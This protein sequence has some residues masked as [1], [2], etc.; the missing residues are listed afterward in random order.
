MRVLALGSYHR[1]A[2]RNRILLRGLREC[3][4]L[5]SERRFPM[6]TLKFRGTGLTLLGQLCRVALSLP[7]YCGHMVSGAGAA[8]EADVVFIGYLGHHDVAAVAA[9]RRVL[10]GLR[11]KPVVF[12]PF[13]S[14]YDTVVSDRGLLSPRCLPARVLWRSE[15]WLLTAADLVLADTATHGAYYRAMAGLPPE[16]VRVVPVGVDEALFSARE[17]RPEAGPLRIL[18][19]GTYIPLHGIETILRAAHLVREEGLRFR[20]IGRGQTRPRADALARELRLDSV[21]FIDWV[22]MAQLPGEI[23]QSD[24][25]LGIFGM[26]GKAARVV[27]N[28]VY[29]AL[30]VG[31]CVVTRDSPALREMFRP[32]EHLAVCPPGDAEALAHT[33]Q[34]LARNTALRQELAEAGC[35]IVHEQFSTAAIGRVFCAALAQAVERRA[36]SSPLTDRT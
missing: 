15:R 12:D 3:G 10:R 23:A 21:E 19:Y 9:L 17:Y 1:D 6:E 2:D 24:I 13:F 8:A 27:P 33:I 7:K 14:L 36:R 32:G 29:Q 30:S 11:G 5:V 20:L 26:T 18:F 25:V 28:K 4:V 34:E 31:R 35:R 22:P 16:R